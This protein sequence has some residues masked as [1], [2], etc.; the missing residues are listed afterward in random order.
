MNRLGTKLGAVFLAAG[1]VACVPAGGGQYSNELATEEAE[2]VESSALS[3]TFAEAAETW[4]V[5]VDVLKAVAYLETNLEPAFGETEFDNQPEPWGLFALR[6]EELTLAAELSGYDVEAVKMETEANVQA[7]AALLSHYAD[8]AEID[9]ALRPEPTQWG[10]A[11]ELMGEIDMDLRPVHSE[12]V[13]D[14]IRKGLAVPMAD[15]TTMLIGRHAPEAVEGEI[16]SSVND[17]RDGTAVWRP[18]PNNSSRSGARPQFIVI[19]TCEGA[20]SGCVSWLR[21][22]RSGVSAHYVVNE[23]GSEISQLV[24]ENRKAWHIGARY[25]SSLNSGRLSHLNNRASNTYSIGIEHGGRSSQRTWS[26]GLIT[27]SVNL[28]RRIANRHNIPKDRYHIVAHGRLQPESRTD[29]GPNWP[30]SSYLSRIAQ[31]STPPP[32]PPPTTPPPTTPPPTTPPPSATVITI[33]NTTSGRFRASN[34]WDASSWASGKVGSNYRFRSPGFTSDTAEWRIP[35]GTAGRYEVFARVPGN[36]YNTKAPY[37][38]HHQGGRTVV[39][40]NISR[41]GGKWMS[42]GTYSFAAK[43]DW[44]VQLSR[45]TNG[46]GY[47]IAD[48]IRFER[49]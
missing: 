44:V 23:A 48:A 21:Q 8:Q 39:N 9:I 33:D 10:P 6:G 22:T 31:G 49:R 14:H 1:W 32:P 7:A 29:P 47:L 36:G 40:K 11:I 25:R 43:D 28:V 12:S 26:S 4:E 19:H 5:P 46:N 15:G 16:A 13:L 17:L 35:V 24:D 38:I 41:E 18:S 37:I 2:V 27:S 34:N 20:Y 30:W 42:L 45:W 3:L